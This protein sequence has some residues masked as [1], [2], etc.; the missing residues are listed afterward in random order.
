MSH[1]IGNFEFNPD[2][3]FFNGYK[4]CKF[5]RLCKGCGEYRPIGKR[6]LIIN[7]DA[8]GDVLMTTAMLAPL[9]RKYGD[10]AFITWITRA[11]AMS[12][13]AH[14]PLVDRVTPYDFEG[15][16]VVKRQKF[17]AAFNVDK[18]ANSCA[19]LNEVTAKHKFGFGL[20]DWGTIMPANKENAYNF[21][22][23]LNDDLKFRQN[24]LAGTQILH[25]GMNLGFE[26]DE[27]I[28]EQ[29]D[30]EKEYIQAYKRNN[31]LE[32]RK[33]IGINTG[34]SP[35]YA[36]KKLS[37]DQYVDLCRRLKE[38]FPKATVALVGG[39][40]ETE[41][42]RDIAARAGDVLATPTDQGLR[43]GIGFIDL[44][45]IIITGDTMAVHIGIALK[46]FMVPFFTL[47]CPAEL[48][49]YDRGVKIAC[50]LDC[51][52]CWKRECDDLR[53]ITEMDLDR[54]VKGV[55]EYFKT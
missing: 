49:L 6:L 44:C 46:K 55:G 18:S 43:R 33:I 40:A 5:K 2:C 51:A 9:R 15:S 23:G 11:N 31:K 52:P 13:L 50:E 29:T 3:R 38:A 8:M 1:K 24:K 42:N 41:F 19:L 30:E 22:M 48:D 12:L 21:E 20:S 27:Y 4:P 17:D 10:D 25:E 37:A 47:T 45:D 35:L 34:C 7:L 54:I 53:C 36:N 28:L 32:G 26:R 39:K 16:L 14:N